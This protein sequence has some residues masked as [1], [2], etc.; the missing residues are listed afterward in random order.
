MK[1]TAIVILCF[2]ISNSFVS[3]QNSGN[4]IEGVAFIKKGDYEAA[5]NSLSKSI[6]EE[7]R[8]ADSYFYR[9]KSLFLNTKFNDAEDDFIKSLEYGNKESLIYLARCKAN[10]KNEK[11]AIGYLDKYLKNYPEY[12][13]TRIKNDDNF[14]QIQT[15]D[16]WFNFIS[17]IEQ[18]AI[19]EKLENIDYLINNKQYIKA[20]SFSQQAINSF[21]ASISLHLK[22]AEIYASQGNFQLAQYEA[23][24]A[25]NLEPANIQAILEY[26]KYAKMNGKYEQA[27]EKLTELKKIQPEI[28]DTYI[29]L[30][31]TMLASSDASA[32]EKEID[33]YLEY[34]P[35]DINALFIKAQI[36]YALNKKQESLKI[37]NN[38]INKNT[39][40]AEWFKLRGMVLFN[41]NAYSFAVSDLSMSLDLIPDDAETNYYL[42]LS[43]KKL[44]N[45]SSAC[46]YLNRAYKYGD[47]R[48]FD[49]ISEECK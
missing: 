25:F 30:A 7:N 21:P 39:A 32:A 22:L 37:L 43:Y 3:A 34:F 31:E 44:N 13:I 46:Y 16:A 1:K 9:G 11:D 49:Y 12:S 6:N 10:Q 38:L 26:S 23:S 48:A 40:K 42:G 33:T 15:S 5:Y 47:N 27:I 36:E 17:E 41:S 14:R 45:I 29:L 28:F 24:N 2:F 18:N 20:E 35:G 4:L 19:C 8:L